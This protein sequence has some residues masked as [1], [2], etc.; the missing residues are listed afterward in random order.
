MSG[1]VAAQ[2]VVLWLVPAVWA[3]VANVWPWPADQPPAPVVATGH[4]AVG[5]RAR[6][7][8]GLARR[9]AAARATR[10]RHWASTS[11]QAPDRGQP[12]GAPSTLRAPNGH[13]PHRK[14]T[15]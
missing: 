2:L 12:S 8:R 3:L 6:S 14:D 4:L 15:P 10:R 1:A 5:G 9:L 7:V 11:P 13:R